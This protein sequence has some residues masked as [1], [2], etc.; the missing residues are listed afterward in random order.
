MASQ[1]FPQCQKAHAGL[2]LN[3]RALCAK[4]NRAEPS[5]L[6]NFS[7]GEAVWETYRLQQSLPLA[8][9]ADDN[10]RIS[11]LQG[12][13]RVV[14]QERDSLAKQ[15]D[16]NAQ[17]YAT[18]RAEFLREQEDLQAQ[19]AT[20]K[21]NFAKT[22]DVLTA[23]A[24]RGDVTEI[25]KQAIRVSRVLRGETPLPLQV[26]STLPAPTLQQDSDDLL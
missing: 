3:I 24:R 25:A 11:Q 14:A 21:N 7:E 10:A 13:L 17:A 5:G 12:A 26:P 22:L 19:V 23:L 16:L 8:V 18:V 2:I 6:E 1:L 9:P 20:L 4:L 15:V